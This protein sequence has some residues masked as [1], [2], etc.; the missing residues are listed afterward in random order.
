MSNENPLKPGP[1]ALRRYFTEYAVLGLTGAVMFLFFAYRDLNNY[2][3]ETLINSN[4]EQRATIERNTETLRDLKNY[5][6]T[7]QN[8]KK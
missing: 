3:R 7:E 2:I 1:S 6:L 8:N 5:L 4:A